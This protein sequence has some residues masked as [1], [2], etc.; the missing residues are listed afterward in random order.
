MWKMTCD[1]HAIIPLAHYSLGA[2]AH[3]RMHTVGGSRSRKH[4]RESSVV[5]PFQLHVKIPSML[6]TR[7]CRSG[8]RLHASVHILSQWPA[9]AALGGQWSLDMVRAACGMHHS[10]F[11]GPP[12]VSGKM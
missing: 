4:K 7:T 5:C 1:L 6:L 8:H 10:E 2:A 11:L 9:A 3:L 12:P